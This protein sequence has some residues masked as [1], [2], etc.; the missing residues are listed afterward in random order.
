MMIVMMVM[1]KMMMLVICHVDVIIHG[2]G[3]ESYD[4]MMLMHGDDGGVHYTDG[5]FWRREHHGMFLS[6]GLK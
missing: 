6:R 5:D 2:D 1:M 3:N 4:D